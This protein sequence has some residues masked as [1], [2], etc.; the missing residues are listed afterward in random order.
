M[1]SY[2]FKEYITFSLHSFLQ[3]NKILM[4]LLIFLSFQIYT[5]KYFT[6]DISVVIERKL[7][8]TN[9]KFYATVA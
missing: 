5:N 4:H 6:P 8:K 2:L 1:L 9:M 7:T 3:I